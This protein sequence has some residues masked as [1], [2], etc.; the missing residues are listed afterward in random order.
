M[1][2]QPRGYRWPASH[3]FNRGKL[4]EKGAQNR[5]ANAAC[6]GLRHSSPLTDCRV[7]LTC[8]LAS[9]LPSVKWEHPFTIP[10]TCLNRVLGY[11]TL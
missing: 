3:I 2:L 11:K 5:G 10:S 8:L 9:V 6:R 7:C 1:L 4:Y